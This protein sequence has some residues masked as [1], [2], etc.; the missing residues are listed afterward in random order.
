MQRTSVSHSSSSGS[1]HMHAIHALLLDA[2][3][4]AVGPLHTL[5]NTSPSSHHPI[6][7]CNLT[8]TSKPQSRI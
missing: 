1:F 5:S 3:S 6:D 4:Y 8:H 2:S 7:T